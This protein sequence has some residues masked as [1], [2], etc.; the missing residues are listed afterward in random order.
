MEIP[1]ITGPD[2]LRAVKAA[3]ADMPKGAPFAISLYDAEDLFKLEPEDLTAEEFGFSPEVAARIVAGLRN[4]DL[5]ELGHALGI[6][7]IVDK[8]MR[9][10]LIENAA[11][12]RTAGIA[13]DDPETYE[14]MLA[15]FDQLRHPQRQ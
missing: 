4:G 14:E 11:I 15:F 5:T 12:I 9:E 7:L 3:T 10:S 6:K 2:V 8:G 1:K 13:A